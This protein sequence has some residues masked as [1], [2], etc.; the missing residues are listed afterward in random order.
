[1]HS[2]HRGRAGT[3]RP[4]TQSPKPWLTYNADEVEQLIVK[5][6]KAGKSSANIGMVLR[7][8]YGIPDAKMITNKSIL[9]VLQDHKLSSEIPETLMQLIKKEIKLNKHL[10]KN[11]KDMPTRR[12]LLL[13]TSKIRRLIKYY[14]RTKALP[15][16]WVYNKEQIKTT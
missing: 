8:T 13:T 14:K 7:D 5:L 9:R 2:R 12:G 3:K 10:V 11:K 4:E 16:N 15:Q 6:A 1:M